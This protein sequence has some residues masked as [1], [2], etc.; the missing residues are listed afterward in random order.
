MYGKIRILWKSLLERK[1]KVNLDTEFS[2]RYSEEEMLDTAIEKS[3]IVEDKDEEIYIMTS[4]LCIASAFAALS[5]KEEMEPLVDS[6]EMQIDELIDSSEKLLDVDM[7]EQ[8]CN[9]IDSL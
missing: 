7:G 2:K 1:Y 6:L 8:I 3:E 4:Y 9:L 5:I